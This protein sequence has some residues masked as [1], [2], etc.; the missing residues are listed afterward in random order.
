MGEGHA[1]TRQHRGLESWE[2]VG[3]APAGARWDGKGWRSTREWDGSCVSSPPCAHGCA[4]GVVHWGLDGEGGGVLLGAWPGQGAGERGGRSVG[5]PGRV[6]TDSVSSPPKAASYRPQVASLLQ[7]RKCSPSYQTLYMCV[8]KRLLA[9][10]GG[11]AAGTP[12]PRGPLRKAVRV[13]ASQRGP[14]HTTAHSSTA[15]SRGW[16]VAGQSTSVGTPMAHHE[17]R[18]VMHRLQGHP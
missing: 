18:S 10:G 15:T 2:G 13:A 7:G 17:Q 6:C 14:R 11:L 5:V 9:S 8:A 1:L 16:S 3:R 12:L 4:L